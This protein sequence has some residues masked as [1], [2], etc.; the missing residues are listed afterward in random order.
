MTYMLENNLYRFTAEADQA[1][2]IGRSYRDH[3]LVR[4]TALDRTQF[5]A[6][7]EKVSTFVKERSFRQ[8]ATEENCRFPYSVKLMVGEELQTLNGCRSAFD[9]TSLGRLAREAEFLMY[10]PQAGH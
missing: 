9:G 7:V 10:S 8:L 5:Q 3:Q 2:V 6:L 4:Q 1:G